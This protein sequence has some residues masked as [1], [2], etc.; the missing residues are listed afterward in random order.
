MATFNITVQVTADNKEDAEAIVYN[1][2]ANN[3]VD[4]VVG[5]AK[6]LA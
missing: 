2:L 3:K 4:A 5:D 6:E 1:A